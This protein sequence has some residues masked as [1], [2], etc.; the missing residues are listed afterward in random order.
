MHM[1]CQHCGRRI[2]PRRSTCRD[3]AIPTC[4]VC[5]EPCSRSLP[6]GHIL[7]ATCQPQLRAAFCPLC[8]GELDLSSTYSSVHGEAKVKTP[9]PRARRPRSSSDLARELIAAQLE[10]GGE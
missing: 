9:S 8:K 10:E 1:A 2:S 4:C 5:L 6:C 7:C 3:C